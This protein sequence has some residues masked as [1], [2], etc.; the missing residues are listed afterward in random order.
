MTTRMIAGLAAALTLALGPS[1]ASAA[2]CPVLIKQLRE[3]QVADGAKAAEV[4]RLT[5]EAQRLH[6]EGKHAES[7]ARA[8]E[9]AKVGG[10]QLQKR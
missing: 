4:K 2:Q 8:E 3:A 10:I 7:V 6:G 9:A 5:D 1:L